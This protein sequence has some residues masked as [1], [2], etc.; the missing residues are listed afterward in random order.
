MTEFP[1]PWFKHSDV[2]GGSYVNLNGITANLGLNA[3]VTVPQEPAKNIGSPWNHRLAE[4]EY[5]G[6]DNPRY[7]FEGFIPSGETIDA[8]GSVIIT[9]PLL[10][11]FIKLGSPIYFRDPEMM[12]NPAG[13]AAVL[14]TNF[15]VE[16]P[17][18]T[19][20]RYSVEF[21][22]TKSW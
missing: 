14:V 6:I 16:K 9:V 13:S 3:Y 10:G 20:R 12:L 4:A 18:N 7:V 15:K 1:Y 21:V 11:S 2:N 8:D 5:V 22:E 17:Q 19:G